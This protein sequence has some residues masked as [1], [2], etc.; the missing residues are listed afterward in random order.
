MWR[1]RWRR[2]KKSRVVIVIKTKSP[3]LMFK[4]FYYQ[5]EWKKFPTSVRLRDNF[6][7]WTI[8]NLPARGNSS[9]IFF[10]ICS[11][12]YSTP[13]RKWYLYQALSK[14]NVLHT[15]IRISK[16]DLTFL[17]LRSIPKIA[18]F[19]DHFFDLPTPLS[20]VAVFFMFVTLPC[21]SSA[22]SFQNKS[23]GPSCLKHNY[24]RL[25]LD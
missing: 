6:V 11:R 13:L 18:A 10:C 20:D 16:Y 5:K 23:T 25:I 3:K 9:A 4:L 22:I 8:R 21:S 15:P 24:L 17:S 7:K 19:F 1:R 14:T 2:R 12:L